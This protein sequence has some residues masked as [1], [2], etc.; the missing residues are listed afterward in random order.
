MSINTLDIL[1]EYV[2]GPSIFTGRRRFFFIQYCRFC[3]LGLDADRLYT[4]CLT[5]WQRQINLGSCNRFY[6]LGW[7]I[8]VL[9]CTET[10]EPQDSMNP[11]KFDGVPHK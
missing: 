8:S 6:S 9:L 3:F 4:K 7:R 11:Q 1:K 5:R 10:E 2:N